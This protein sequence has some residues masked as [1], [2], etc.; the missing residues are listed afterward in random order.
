MSR[1]CDPRVGINPGANLNDPA[2]DRAL[3]LPDVQH[4]NVQA[5][6]NLSPFIGTNLELFAD[7]INVLS[8]R[9]PLTVVE[10]DGPRFGQVATRMAP[11]TVRLGFR[12]KY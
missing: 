5:R 8:L 3:R 7:V 1:I 6:A 2:D 10:V 12:L 9:T 4:L 11:T